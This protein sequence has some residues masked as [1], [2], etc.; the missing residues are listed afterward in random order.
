MMDQHSP[1]RPHFD[2]ASF[3]LPFGE[4][5]LQ[6]QV[7]ELSLS[8]LGAGLLFEALSHTSW[9]HEHPAWPH[10]SN[11]RLEFLG[12]AVLELWCSQTLFQRFPHLDEG[13]LSRLR[14]HIVSEETLGEWGRGLKLDQL[15]LVGKGE[16]QRAIQHSDGP[17][18]GLFEAILGASFAGQGWPYSCRVLDSWEQLFSRCN[19]RELFDTRNLR[20]FDPKGQLQEKS[21]AVLGELP[22]YIAE[23]VEGGYKIS[24]KLGGKTLASTVAPS[25]KKAEKALARAA[26]EQSWP[27]TGPSEVR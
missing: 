8:G 22:E 1:W 17:V 6:Q 9:V 26:L 13:Q 25:K 10:P 19:G 3:P 20:T 5:A 27:R 7:R 14:G 2:L 16:R 4:A 12:D 15:L 18:S 11:E 24:L 21:M 23:E